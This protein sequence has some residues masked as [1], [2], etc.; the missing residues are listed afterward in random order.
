MRRSGADFASYVL[1]GAL[2]PGDPP[3]F[4]HNGGDTLA[5]TLDGPGRCLPRLSGSRPCSGR[6]VRLGPGLQL[7]RLSER[8]VLRHGGDDVFRPH[9]R[10]ARQ[11][12]RRRGHVVS[13]DQVRDDDPA[14]S[15]SD[16]QRRGRGPNQQ[17]G[18]G[19]GSQ[20]PAPSQRR[21]RQTG[22]AGPLRTVQRGGMVLELAPDRQLLRRHG[23]GAR[24]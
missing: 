10:H 24:R 20:G 14:R 11:C 3:V 1:T 8:R 13:A 4:G 18:E 9:D 6:S 2:T 22:V 19:A 7:H 5:G 15:E 21:R 17:G 16:A 12:G 23:S